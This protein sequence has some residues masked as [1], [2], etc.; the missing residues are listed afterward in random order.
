V[1]PRSDT[2]KD[3][4]AAAVQA[5]DGASLVIVLDDDLEGVSRETLH[6]AANLVYLGTMLPDQARGASLV[7]PMANIAE[8]DGTLVNRDRRV[9]RYFQAK[10]A[11]GM[12]RPAWWVLSEVL[13]EMGR[14]DTL[15]S[16]EEAFALMA[17]S[18]SA[19]QGLGY[20]SLGT[21]GKTMSE[22]GVSV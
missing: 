19:F 8:E 2:R 5:I 9:Q 13:K 7:L 16:A 11:P 14:G 6:G 4:F 3:D 15:F 17:D 18:E 20:A 10:S 12:A 1:P 22:V 21:F